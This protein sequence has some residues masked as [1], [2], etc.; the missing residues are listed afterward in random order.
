M[1]N[2]FQAVNKQITNCLKTTCF[3]WEIYY[4]IFLVCSPWAFLGEA[5]GRPLL[6]DI[7]KSSIMLEQK[8]HLGVKKW[9]YELSWKVL[10]KDRVFNSLSKIFHHVFIREANLEQNK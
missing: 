2:V 8:A 3:L 7:E 5:Q 9:K 6:Q 4:I 10:A 1:N